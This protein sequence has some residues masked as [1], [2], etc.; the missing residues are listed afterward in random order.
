MDEAPGSPRVVF[1]TET[2]GGTEEDRII[3][4]GLVEVIGNMPTGREYHRRFNPQ[5]RPIHWGAQRVHGIRY[6]D[7]RDKPFF[8]N[9]IGEILDF[10]G[11]RRL[12]AHNAA[13]DA[14]MLNAELALAGRPRLHPRRFVDTVT[15]AKRAW[16]GQRC[17]MDALIERLMPDRR[18]GQHSALEDAQLLAAMMPHF[19][20]VHDQEVDA[21]LKGRGNAPRNPAAATQQPAAVVVP[22]L[23]Q[24][25]K[26][27]VAEA[28]ARAVTVEEAAALRTFGSDGWSKASRTQLIEVLAPR[29][30]ADVL[31]GAIADLDG[32]SG[33]AA[34]R[35]VCRGL[36]LDLA[37]GRERVYLERKRE[38]EAQDAPSMEP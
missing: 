1:D 38:R 27:G 36:P 7:L 22:A 35:W 4:I 5:G 21:L 15:I 37:V 24:G 9:C 6:R 32:G 16:P 17:G 20:P 2:T 33:D 25:M 28:I 8:K 11:D 3:E 26:E 10:I 31:L 19:V 34:L 30:A 14:R 18:R 23:G 13:F 12:Y 29:H